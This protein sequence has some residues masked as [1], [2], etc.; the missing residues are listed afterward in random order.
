MSEVKTKEP[1]GATF[2]KLW[3]ASLASNISD[4]LF[5]TAAPLLAAS[6]THDP[7]LISLMAALVM[8][9]WLLFAIPI[10]A[11]VDRVDRRIALAVAN[12]VRFAMAA[13][14]AYW[15]ATDQI[16][17]GLL[18]LVA[19][20]I[21]IAE[22][23]YDTTAQ[24]L[25]PQILKP[26][27]LERGNARL[28]IGATVVGEFIGAPLSGMLY[29]IA[30]AIP[31]ISG[32]AGIAIATVL[33]LLIPV[34]FHYDFERAA[35]AAVAKV[36]TGYWA[37]IRFGIRYLYEDKRLLKLVL[38]TT[39]VG[40]WFSASGSTQV[41]FFL[42]ELHVPVAVFGFIMLTPAVG[43]IVGAWLAPK[44][45][46]RF[47]RMNVM[48]LAIVG[49][50]VLVTIGGFSPNIYF[51]SSLGILGGMMMSWWNILLMSTYHQ[52]IPNELFGRIH[53]TRRTLVWGM[54]PLGSLVGGAIATIGL[55]EAIIIPGLLSTLI[56]L[57]GMK[58]VRSLGNMADAN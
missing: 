49:S 28:E 51:W 50:G 18:Y 48:S 46:K 31:F 3:T 55:R 35:A 58:F 24:A 43:N 56:A 12:G 15:V 25:I 41:L 9:P 39:S 52:I 7:V 1:L 8:L 32:A 37:D 10:G 53:G 33:V 36:R 45:S 22:V 2:N 29:A 38:F 30:I 47:G 21:G 27:H 13:T 11:I 16:N 14:L 57:F 19:F 4:G 17:I 42:N 40:F 26:S 44:V 5:K 54:M 20:V 23:A 6:L 34:K